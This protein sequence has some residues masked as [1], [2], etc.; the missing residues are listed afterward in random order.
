MRRSGYIRR[1]SDRMMQ[2]CNSFFF[3]FSSRRRH[4][5]L[6]GDWSSDV[7]SSDLAFCQARMNE[8]PMRPKPLMP[9]RVATFSSEREG[10]NHSV[11]RGAR[12]YRDRACLR[13]RGGGAYL[14][15][16]GLMSVVISESS[17]VESET[18]AR[19]S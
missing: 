5:R 8:R 2:K 13:G 15:S 16:V 4:T 6:Q 17:S 1:R 7:C 11:G 19:A 18:I 12:Q 3:F 14:E 9:I 10:P